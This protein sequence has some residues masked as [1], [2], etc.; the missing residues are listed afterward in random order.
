VTVRVVAEQEAGGRI[1]SFLSTL[2]IGALAVGMLLIA[3][4]LTGVLSF[5]NPFG[6]TTVDRSTPTL[7]RVSDSRRTPREVTPA[8]HQRDTA[9]GAVVHRR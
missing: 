7:L 3:G 8:D 4:V 6:T 5:A 9:L 2:V 1:G